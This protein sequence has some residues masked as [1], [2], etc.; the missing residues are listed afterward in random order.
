MASEQC[1]QIEAELYFLI[2]RFL[3]SGPCKKSAQTLREELEEFEII[4]ERWSW[5]GTRYRRNFQDWVTLNQHI[6]ADFLL[7]VC[8]QLCPL[9]DT[10]V[11]PSV[12]GLRSLLG[13]GRQSL[14]RTA[15]SSSHTV[16]TGSAVAALH[17]GRPPEPPI[18]FSKQPNIVS[19]IGGR[20]ATGVARLG[21]ALPS[22]TYQH[23]KMHRRIL[24]HLSSVYCVAFDRTGRRIFTVQK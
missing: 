8:E 7:R 23:M 12:P 19:V 6:P 11:P 3:Q 10:H 15:K 5:D 16:W 13:S 24:G 9:L 17:R 14:L 1:S 4:P 2:V 20:Q 21:H 18:I 22:C